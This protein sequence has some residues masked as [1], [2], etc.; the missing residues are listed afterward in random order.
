MRRFG[1]ENIM[2]MME[3]LGFEEDQPIESRMISRAVESAQKRV[4]GNNFDMR[5]VVLQYDD[6]MNQQREI[7]YKQRREVL[8]SDNI[9][10]IV[11]EMIK[12][13]I[14]RIVAAHCEEDIPEE[15]DLQAIVDYAH[16]NLL[17]EGALTKDEL[18]GKE[19]EEI[20]DLLYSKVEKLYD[21]REEQIGAETMREFEKVVVLRAVDSK[22]MDHIDAMDQL[23]QGIHLRAYGGTDP[24]REYQFEGFEMFQEMIEHIQEEITK[25]IMKAHVENNLE[26]QE[27]AKGQTESGGSGEP[28]AKRPVKASEADRIGR[29]DPCPC[30]SGK[31]YKLCHGKA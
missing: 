5:K 22:W 13:V 30:G 16:G 4:E 18:W 8:E 19:K 9:R 2:G 27:V 24:L 21:E 25:Y 14:T 17:Q 7:I 3:R 26:R 10:L 23:R 29:N 6:V 15:W 11:V 28:A 12:P 31:K 20:I 1:A